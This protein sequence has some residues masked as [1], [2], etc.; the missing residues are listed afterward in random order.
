VL[1]RSDL[2]D[3]IT[4]LENELAEF[5]RDN[6]ELLPEE[7]TF[8]RQLLA[9]TEQQL[10]S[11]DQDLRS[12]REREGFLTTELALTDQFVPAD[13]RGGPA[14]SPEA[15]LELLRAELATARARYSASHP[16]VV[17]LQREVAS[18]ESVVGERSGATRLLDQEEALIGELTSLRERYTDAH[19]DVQRVQNELERVRSAIRNLGGRN[20]IGDLGGSGTVR[21]DAYVQLSAQLNSI[22]TQIRSIEEQRRQLREERETLQEQL[23][24]A[25][26]VER[27]YTRLTRSLKNAITDREALAD[28]E[29]SASLSGALESSAVSER[30]VL[31]EPASLPLAPVSPKEKLILAVGFV[32][33]MGCGGAAVMTAEFLDRSIRSTRELS[34]LLGDSPLA[35]IPT[36]VSPAERRLLWG[37]RTAITLAIVFVGAIGL[38]AIHH[39]LTPLDLLFYE[40]RASLTRW[41][42][43]QFANTVISGLGDR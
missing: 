18:L 1:F 38:L 3:R 7:A 19:P 11:L 21:N 30:F 6:R 34:Q 16:D 26:A 39:S 5:Q 4:W 43:L 10:R 20:A 17:R 25:P 12:L 40:A 13:R 29:T 32:L 2:E 28:K 14:A 42:D 27:E 15:Q 8:K 23:A 9:N 33:A 35:T 36:L 22:Q 31:A 37:R 24:R 41:F